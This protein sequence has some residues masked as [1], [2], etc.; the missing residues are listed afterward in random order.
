MAPHH[1]QTKKLRK[2]SNENSARSSR[3]IDNRSVGRK[4]ENKTKERRHIAKVTAN[5]KSNKRQRLAG[6][7]I[8]REI[9]AMDG[10][11]SSESE[12]G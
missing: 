8:K 5:Q 7:Q 12:R 1:T 9:G 4:K 11:G 3:P 2:K 6:Q 10:F